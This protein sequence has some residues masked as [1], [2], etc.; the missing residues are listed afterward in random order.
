MLNFEGN[1]SLIYF[2][3]VAT[4]QKSNKK[5]QGFIK[6]FTE[7]NL[8]NTK[9]KKLAFYICNKFNFIDAQ[10]VFC[11]YR[12]FAKIYLIFIR[13]VRKMNWPIMQVNLIALK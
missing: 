6:I 5:S 4:G 7:N 8:K 10:T 11:F 13:E 9:Q 2:F 12:I 3:P 1:S